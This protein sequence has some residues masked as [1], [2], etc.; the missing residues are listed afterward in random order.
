MGKPSTPY[1]EAV[2][3]VCVCVCI[4]YQ[5]TSPHTTTATADKK[6]SPS[7]VKNTSIPNSDSLVASTFAMDTSE[8][9]LLKCSATFWYS[10]ARFLQ[11]PHPAHWS[12]SNTLTSRRTRGEEK[13]SFLVPQM[14]SNSFLLLGQGV[15]WGEARQ[16]NIRTWGVE[17][18]K[19]HLL[20]LQLS[21]EIL[22][23]QRDHCG[24]IEACTRKGQGH[25]T[26][27]LSHMRH[28]EGHT[29]QQALED[30]NWQQHDGAT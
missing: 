29:S 21:R 24:I 10:G 18:D 23:C 17:L 16:Y 28:T 7:N 5:R 4:R 9:S 26:N 3:I 11:C 14:C 30:A 12:H 19:H 13:H 15:G 27:N 8:P 25:S 2:G 20:G 1:L 6:P 22:S